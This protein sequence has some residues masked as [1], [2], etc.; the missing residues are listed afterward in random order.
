MRPFP[1]SPKG[2]RLGT[3]FPLSLIFVSQLFSA[4]LCKKNVSNV[5]S[6][7]FSCLGGP[8]IITA[9]TNPGLHPNPLL[10]LAQGW[11]AKGYRSMGVP[12]WA[13]GT[14]ASP[15]PGHSTGWPGEWLLRCFRFPGKPGGQEGESVPVQ[16]SRAIGPGSKSTLFSSLPASAPASSCLL[17]GHSGQAGRRAG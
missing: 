2:H 9:T 16:V 6:A 1:S 12:V 17:P 5:Q 15:H 8:D 3:V 13:Q 4:Q 10:P 7:L 14:R 11:K